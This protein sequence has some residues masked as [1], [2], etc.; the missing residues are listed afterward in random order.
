MRW[1]GHVVRRERG[2]VHA[3]FWCGNLRERDHFENLVVD[4]LFKKWDTWRGLD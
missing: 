2:E 3:G 4:G 1:T